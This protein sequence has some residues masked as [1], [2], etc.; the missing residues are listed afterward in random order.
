MVGRALARATSGTAADA[1]P[2]RSAS[3]TAP[4]ADGSRCWR[5]PGVP[6][7]TRFASRLPPGASASVAWTS[8]PTRAPTRGDTPSAAQGTATSTT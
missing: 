8:N 5:S 1:G 7:Q 3:R 4:N 6:A 2:A